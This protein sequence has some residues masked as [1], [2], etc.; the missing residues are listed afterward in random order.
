MANL[1]AGGG[2][3][4][5]GFA[6]GVGGEVIVMDIPLGILGVDGV[7]LL[8]GGQGVQGADGKHLGLTAGEQAGA[9]DSGQHADFGV[10]GTDFVHALALEQPLLD[11]LLLHL[12]QADLDVG[13]EVFVLFAE[14]LLE[15]QT[16]G[17]QA[18]LP[19]VLVGGVQSV[20]DLIQAVGHQIV[21]QLVV[22]GGL[23]EGELGLADLGHDG[24][25]E[26]DD[27]HVG[28]V[29]DP[30]ALVD[31]VLG[32]FLGLGLDHD[33]LLEG[34]GDAHETVGGVPL[35]GGGV[36]DILAVQM[37]DV[38]GGHGAVPGNVG[39]GNGDGSAQGR[40]DLHGVIVVVGKNGA[41]HDGVVAQLLV[42]EGTHG[43]VDDAAVQDA[44]LGGLALPA[45]KGAGDAAHGIHTLLELDGQG[46]VVD[47]GLGN[48][49]AGD[50]GEH[51]GVAVAAD[52]LGVGQLCDLAGLDRKGTA[53]DLGLKNVVIRILLM[54]DHERTSFVLLRG[55][56]ST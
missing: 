41:G 16:G 8:G 11:D 43:T 31:D 22:D 21:Q 2:T 13:V 32:G 36:D 15:V 50:G 52:A 42:K 45:V 17:G 19:D 10:Q 28:L 30:D 18:L 48:G 5:A 51:D 35:V 38:G 47:S 23:L 12:V 25:D 34:G 1:P 7:D 14:L 49:V 20:L 24:V 33:H 3:G 54:G 40:H 44:P 26:L 29:G 4:G 53:A 6:G 39:A 9:V 37:G 55:R 56:F 46:E 27:L